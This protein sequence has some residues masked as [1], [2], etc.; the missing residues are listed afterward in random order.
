LNGGGFAAFTLG[1]SQIILILIPFR[2]GEAWARWAIPVIILPSCI[3]LLYVTLHLKSTM[4]ASTPWQLPVVTL[5]LIIVAIILS[6][7]GTNK[8][9]Q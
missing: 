3:Y 4:Q 8:P 7:I 6:Y 2:K 5:L 9:T 1:Y